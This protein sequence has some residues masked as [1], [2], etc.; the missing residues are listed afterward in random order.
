MKIS[1]CFPVFLSFVLFSVSCQKKERTLKD[2]FKKS[3]EWMWAQQSEDGGW[4]SQTHAVLRD[5]RVLTPYIL[6]HLLQ[7][8][9][10]KSTTE[11]KAI[12]KGV[13]FIKV[14]YSLSDEN[15]RLDDYPNYSAAF[16]LKVFHKLQIDAT[17][18]ESIAQYLIAQQ[19]D[20]SREFD[21][22]HLVY[23]GWGY[24]EILKRGEHGHVDVSHTRRV[25]EAL[26]ES[27]YINADILKAT[28]LF[29][30]A[31]Q[32]RKDDP[33]Y[34]DS[35]VIQKMDFD[36]GFISSPVTLETNKSIPVSM[37][38]CGSKFPSYAT[39]TCDGFL[40]L[41]SLGM[42]KSGMY[43][44]AKKWLE[45]NKNISKIDGL[46]DDDPEQWTEIMHYYHF[47]VRAEAMSI[48][49]PKGAW[50][51]SLSGLLIK[52]Q[53]PDGSYMNPIGGVNKE[54][55]PLMATIF[56]IQAGTRILY[57]NNIQ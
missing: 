33:R 13:D 36:G 34:I 10:E 2:T 29:L 24:G 49:E 50:R 51:D 41:H 42:E 7:T 56:C 32:H 55:D 5:G 31:A 38:S 53:L 43:D 40:A 46:G 26:V 57:S 1:F 47:A 18:Q 4:H 22:T 45:R 44:D 35:C 54:D 20:N 28:L 19:F 17:L 12:Q 48:I 8:P 16:A 52:E 21:Q 23:G 9:G 6:F 39:A 30:S 27:E 3:V 37:D 25:V 11:K 15:K 14:K